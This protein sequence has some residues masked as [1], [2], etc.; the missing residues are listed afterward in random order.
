[1]SILG[2]YPSHRYPRSWITQRLVN[3]APSWSHI[4]K[5]PTSVG[6]QVL[7]PLALD[8]QDTLQQLTR[9]RY[10]QFAS[11]ADT[12]QLGILYRLDLPIE[13]EFTQTSGQDGVV[14]YTAP[15]VYATVNGTEYQITMAEDNDLLTLGYDCLPSRIE[16]AE[17]SYSYNAVIPTTTISDLSLVSP[18]S[19]AIKGHLYITIAGNENW[20]LTS[21]D[22]IYYS[23]VYIAGTTRKGTLVTEALP[24]RYNGTFKT[25]N[26]WD[27][28]SSVSVS[29]MSDTATITVESFPFGRESYLDT[30]NVLIEP[31]QERFGFVR[32]EERTYGTSLIT[33]GFVSPNMNIVRSGYNE[34]QIYH[35]IELL[36]EDS[37]NVTLTDFVI[38][39]NT[40]F[41]Y[42]IDA[43]NFYV[44]DI[45]LPY[46]DARDMT[47]ESP[48]TKMDLYCDRWI[49]N[50]DD[51]VNIKTRT[52]AFTDPPVRVRWS[53][54]DPTG[55]EYRLFLDGS[56]DAITNEEWIDNVE[57]DE[58]FWREQQIP[59]TFDQS[60]IW[61]VTIECQYWSDALS[62]DTILKTKFLFFVP[63]I[64]P[65]V[66]FALPSGLQNSDN[67]G[68]DS[69][70]SIW[71]T[72]YGS[73][74]K[75]DIFH[76]Y[77]LTD[78]ENKR[79]WMRE[80][81]SNVRV[82]IS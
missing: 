16:D 37:N 15:S 43:T 30:F 71:L 52:L 50:K 65:E 67:I 22:R 68:I 24:I 77:F 35:E 46:P 19:I 42:A 82:A 73:I 66:Q 12:N 34:K 72:N 28:I 58:G 51:E 69:D 41:A 27:S 61:I 5:S 38:K 62:I 9:E 78:Y 13:M 1:M 64:V 25:L 39:P 14:V 4:R 81:Y 55:T 33:E 47:G 2:T 53:V 45:S 10:N 29:Y 76:D 11:S 57:R 26:E 32:L 70:G 60:G 18:G 48:E 3:R 6:Q 17:V 7:N 74:N 8:I 59:L 56:T 23:K 21:V 63:S 31:D 36:D 54:L 75:L 49:C 20:E 40:R 44:Y 80:E 79:L